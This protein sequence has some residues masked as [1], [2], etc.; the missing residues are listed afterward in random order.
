MKVYGLRKLSGSRD[1]S[2]SDIPRAK[3]AKVAK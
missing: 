3:I 1:P 2:D